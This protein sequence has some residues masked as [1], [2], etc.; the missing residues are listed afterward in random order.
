M[1]VFY[2]TDP[3]RIILRH[4]NN[5]DF[6]VELH[7]WLSQLFSI[8]LSSTSILNSPPT[9]DVEDRLCIALQFTFTC[10]LRPLEQRLHRSNATVHF[11]CL[12]SYK[13]KYF[14]RSWTIAHVFST[15]TLSHYSVLLFPRWCLKVHYQTC[16]FLL[17]ITPTPIPFG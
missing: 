10:S 13:T 17:F 5:Y 2:S 16:R 1:H 12:T 8:P 11:P 7:Q 15:Y 9:S 4:L 6:L 14:H 3:G